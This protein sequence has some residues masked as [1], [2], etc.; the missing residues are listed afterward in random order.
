[1]PDSFG[2]NDRQ[3]NGKTREEFIT[4]VNDELTIS[5]IIP[6]K[7]PI[8]AVESLIKDSLDFFYRKYPDA[9][10]EHYFLVFKEYLQS[11]EFKSSRSIQLPRQIYSVVNVDK[12]KNTLSS[13]KGDFSRNKSIGFSTYG[14]ASSTDDAGDRTISWLTQMSLFSLMDD[15]LVNHTVGYNFNRLTRKMSIRGEAP[16]SDMVIET[17]VRVDEE[18]LFEDDYFRKYVRALAK[19]KLAKIMGFFRIPLPGNVEVDFDGL[20]SE[21]KEEIS[22]IE[23]DIKEEDGI[24]DYM[25]ME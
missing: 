7:L 25:F 21:G 1:M 2:S 16:N 14:G 8:K 13:G 17:L 4:E 12:M 20:A 5:G 18:Y 6:F 23:E 22:K 3:I 19:V 24:A 9:L 10:Q 11:E 15:I